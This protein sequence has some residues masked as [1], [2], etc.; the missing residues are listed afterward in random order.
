MQVLSWAGTLIVARLLRPYDY[1]VM[2][3]GMIFIALADVLAEAGVGGALVQK[4]QLEPR[5]LAEGFTLSLILS[6]ALCTLLLVAAPW[7][8]AFLDDRDLPSLLRLLALS[9]LLTPL[10]AIP[11]ALLERNLELR[12]QSLA[13]ALS[14]IVPLSLVLCLAIGGYGF[15]ALAWGTLTTRALEAV[16]LP[17]LAGWRPSIVIPGHHAVALLRFGIHVSLGA[18]LWF[19]WSNA[20]YAVVSK[21]VGPAALGYYGLAFQLISLPV[22]KL[23]GNVNQAAYPLYC[24]IQHDRARLRDWYLRVTALLSL[25]GMP[26]LGGMAIVADDAFALVLGEKWLPAVGPFQ[27]LAVVGMLMTVSYS[28]SPLINALGRP[29]INLR[30]TIISTIILP[31]GFVIL[32]LTHGL[33]GICWAWLILYPLIEVWIVHST[34]HLTGCGVRDLAIAQLPVVM[35]MVAMAAT[36]LLARKLLSDLSQAVLRLGATI[37]VGALT[38]VS[39]MLVVARRTVVADLRMLLQELRRDQRVPA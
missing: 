37:L 39:F 35:G 8:G 12:R 25:L 9:L 30:Y 7:A 22:Q 36:T 6:I 21:V 27:V 5:D 16:M 38:Y 33:V 15:W 32:G 10:R 31:S 1:G 11:M 19:A 26:V 2:T 17:Y 34:R 24:R 4:E 29:D 28:L 23:T 14:V 20:D 13:Y 3:T 18:L